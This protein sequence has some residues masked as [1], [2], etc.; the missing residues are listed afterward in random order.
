MWA[1]LYEAHTLAGIG[2]QA[3]MW[4][5]CAIGDDNLGHCNP[6]EDTRVKELQPVIEAVLLLLALADYNVRS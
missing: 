2:V 1:Y 3:M 6:F 4:T 5:H